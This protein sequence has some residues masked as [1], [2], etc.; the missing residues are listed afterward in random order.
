MT[1]GPA[2]PEGERDG[3]D[4]DTRAWSAARVPAAV[5]GLSAAVRAVFR[6]PSRMS[7]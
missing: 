2:R 6:P 4:P 7:G 1:T 3:R 5:D